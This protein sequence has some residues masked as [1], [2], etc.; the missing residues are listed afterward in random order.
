MLKKLVKLL[1]YQKNQK[2]F[3]HKDILPNLIMEQFYRTYPA[4]IFISPLSPTRERNTLY[5][6][7]RC[8][9][10]PTVIFNRIYSSFNTV[11]LEVFK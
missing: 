11:P 8:C 4:Y 6:N 9:Y 5:D 10:I 3:R 2:I 7:L 1:V